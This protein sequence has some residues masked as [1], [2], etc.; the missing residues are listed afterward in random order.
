VIRLTLGRAW[1]VL[2][3]LAAALAE[4][5]P[6][7]DAL[8]PAGDARRFEPLVSSLVLVGRSG[9]PPGT[10]DLACAAPA[11]SDVLRRTAR[12]A[13]LLYQTT[14][15]DLRVAAPDEY[16]TVLVAATG[17][18]AHVEAL[19]RRRGRLALC[20]TETDVYRHAGLPW[21][22]PELRHA[23]G[24]IEAAL[25]G[26]LP[27]LIVREDIRGDLHMHSTWSD[28]RDS[29]EDMVAMCATLG[30]EYIA[31]TDH[32]E[33]AAAARTVRADELAR[34]RDEIDRLRDR[35]P[36][37]AIL[38]GIEVDVLEDGR[39]DFPDDL[40]E[41]LD[42]VLASVHER[43]NQDG[44]TITRRCARAIRHP[45]VNV[46]SH[47][48]NQLVGRRDGYDMD[49]DT[50]Y[51]AAAETGTALEIDGAPGHLDL[52]GEHARAAVAAGATVTIDSDCHRAWSLD[53]QMLLGIGT[54]RRGWVEARHVLNA[55][56]LDEVR[57]FVAAKRRRPL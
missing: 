24:E 26:A 28:G 13:V 19:T 40:L 9:D 37:L 23:T 10:L 4:L 54:A 21:I 29:I 41:T 45:L 57:A 12:G 47:P 42:I 30:Y 53:R 15:V 44:P 7:L 17:S 6:S 18:A 20:A 32:S 39:L 43:F 34:Q 56:P 52:D 22:P 48:A 11:V 31:I 50:I 35:Y 14:E 16:G 3:S 2:D 46:I 36:A 49:Y 55:R 8:T 27:P 25:A 1:D 51:A 38:H 33:G 5:C